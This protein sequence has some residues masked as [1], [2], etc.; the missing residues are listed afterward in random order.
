MLQNTLLNFPVDPFARLLTLHRAELTR[1]ITRKLGT[2]EAAEDILQDAYMRLSHYQTLDN[3]DN[4]RAFVFRVVANLVIDH[5]RLSANRI[6][7]DSNEEMLHAIPDQQAEPDTVYQTQQRLA[8]IKQA[9]DEL[10]LSCRQAFYLN[11]IEGYSHAN[12]AVKLQIS[13]SMVAKHLLHAMVHC[14][15]RLKNS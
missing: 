8:I 3:I 2:E 5:Q 11:R 4:P 12:C 14:R 9:L 7:H 10:P 15:D 13:E 1:F 6:P